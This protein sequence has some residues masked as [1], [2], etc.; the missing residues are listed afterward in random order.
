MEYWV[1]FEILIIASYHYSI[2]P[3][4]RIHDGN[5]TEKFNLLEM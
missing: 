4:F 1:K 5:N 3:L 2:V